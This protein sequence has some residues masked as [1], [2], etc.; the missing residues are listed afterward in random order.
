MWKIDKLLWL[1]RSGI[2]KASLLIHSGISNGCRQFWK[3]P[4]ASFLFFAGRN[5][6]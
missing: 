2:Q 5:R 3:A 1:I 6:L 4:S